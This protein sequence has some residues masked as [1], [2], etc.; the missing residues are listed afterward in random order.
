MIIQWVRKPLLVCYVFVFCI[1][2]FSLVIAAA[3]LFIVKASLFQLSPALYLKFTYLNA[4]ALVFLNS[5]GCK[6]SLEQ[7]F[8]FT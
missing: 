7:Q 2:N 8:F 1:F 6:N 4:I 3:T 5:C